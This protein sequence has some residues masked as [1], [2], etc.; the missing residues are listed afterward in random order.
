VLPDMEI[1]TIACGLAHSGLVT[2]DG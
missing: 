2:M 1:K